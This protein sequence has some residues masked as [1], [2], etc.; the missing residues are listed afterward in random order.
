M[1]REMFEWDENKNLINIEKHGVD[2]NVA[3]T[4]FNDIHAIVEIDYE[5]SYSEER[6][7]LIGFDEESQLLF[8]CHC[9]RGNDEN[10]IIRLISA[11]KADKT[12]TDL[13]WRERNEK[14]Y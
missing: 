10:D 2:F 6:L 11:R 13:Y 9:D 14:I 3:W 12:E 5:H 4:A 8:V 1:N 7:N